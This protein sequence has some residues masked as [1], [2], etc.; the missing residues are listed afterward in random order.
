MKCGEGMV[1]EGEIKIGGEV[2]GGVC[3]RRWHMK[4]L[5]DGMDVE[6]IF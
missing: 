3:W 6:T 4:G 1:D 5:Y 2:V